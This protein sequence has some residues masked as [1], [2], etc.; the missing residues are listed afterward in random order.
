[1]NTSI[2][3]IK[4]TPTWGIEITVGPILAILLLVIAGI[5]LFRLLNRNFR[6]Q[7]SWQTVEMEL[8][9]G[10][11]GKVKIKPS[12]EIIRVAHQAWTELATRK[13]GLLFDKENDVISEVYDSWYEIFK[14]IRSLIKSIPAEEI[15]NSKDAQ[16]LVDLL[17]DVLN[18]GLRPHLTQWQARFRHWYLDAQKNNGTTS[19]Q[20]LQQKYPEYDLLVADL[21]KVNKQLVEFSDALK[22]IAHE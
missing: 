14:Q 7:S 16:V 18:K 8:S 11:I 19:P 1:M 17:V 15:K 2:L 5:V 13:A 4:L 20:L 3:E 12:Y 9:I 10:N 21:I 22:N 6:K